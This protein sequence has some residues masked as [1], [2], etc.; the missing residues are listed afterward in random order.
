MEG[1]SDPASEAKR[2]GA[3]GE[4]TSGVAFVKRR[5]G[6]REGVPIA[7]RSRPAGAEVEEGGDS[8]RLLRSCD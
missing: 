5:E 2:M 4:E 1:E 8:V 3:E 6:G 7:S